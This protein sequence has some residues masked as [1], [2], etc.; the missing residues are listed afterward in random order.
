[1][2]LRSSEA[3]LAEAQK[4][5]HLG[6]WDWDIVTD[7]LHWSTEILNIFGVAPE[8]F[9]ETYD[10]F[11][12]VI[13]PSDRKLVKASVD[14]AIME[15]EP[16]SIDH[17]IIRPDGSERIVH[18]QG[19][20]KY[21]DDGNAIRMI[22]TVLDITAYKKVEKQFQMASKSAMLYLDLM[23]HDIANQ[24]QIIM[25]CNALLG[26][27][28]GELDNCYLLEMI[29]DAVRECERIVSKTKTTEHLAT[30]P[31]FL[32]DLRSVIIDCIDAFNEDEE[33]LVIESIFTVD[34][35]PI[36]ADDLLECL[37]DN[38]LENA[39]K[40]NTSHDLQIWIKIMQKNYGYEVSIA[41]NGPGI[42]DAIKKDLFNSTRRF[43][44]VGLHQVK[45]ILEKYKGTV[46]VCDRVSNRPEC[47]VEFR[48]WFPRA[49]HKLVSKNTEWKEI[50]NKGES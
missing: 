40:H 5:A 19:E 7:E 10:A 36:L 34:E 37:V 8:D 39:I 2:A 46:E 49:T 13:H 32:R 50:M 23:G 28:L 22:G 43:G 16:Y 17:R 11:L 44:G 26:E 25:S 33:H 18:E 14:R 6:S 29:D 1:N 9:S 31:L 47:G 41:D 42:I 35:A 27:K 4:I 30:A 12:K 24:L 21:D 15:K 20:V 48:L 3:R 38:L 45:E